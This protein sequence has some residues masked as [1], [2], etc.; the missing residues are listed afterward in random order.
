MKV[1]A[2]QF[3]QSYVVELYLGLNSCAY[4]IAVGQGC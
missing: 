4:S 3:A 2:E 1:G